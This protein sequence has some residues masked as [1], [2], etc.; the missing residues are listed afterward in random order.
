[1]PLSSTVEVC[2]RDNAADTRHSTKRHQNYRAISLLPILGK[3]TQMVILIRLQ[4]QTKKLNLIPNEQFGFRKRDS[5]ANQVFLL[6]EQVRGRFNKKES[7][8][9]I[10][11]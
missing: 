8:G 3:L 10:L 7:T 9:A 5:P 1:M 6:V 4:E 2:G 11:L